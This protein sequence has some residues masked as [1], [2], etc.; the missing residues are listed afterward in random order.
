MS[1]AADGLTLADAIATLV[2]GGADACA[3]AGRLGEAAV[4]PP[5]GSG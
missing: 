5:N 2:P 1:A 3:A 4:S